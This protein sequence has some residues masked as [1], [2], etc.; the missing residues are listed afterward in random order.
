MPQVKNPH[1]ENQWAEHGKAIGEIE[2]NKQN[3]S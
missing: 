1:P 3:L 2:L